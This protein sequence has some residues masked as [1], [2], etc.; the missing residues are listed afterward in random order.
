MSTNIICH[1]SSAG[2]SDG[3]SSGNSA[4]TPNQA[5]KPNEPS[6][7]GRAKTRRD[8]EQLILQA[9]ECI[10]AEHGFKGATTSQIA[11]KAKLPKAN[12]HYYFPTKE[13]LYRKVIDRIF[14]IWLEAASAFD[15][16]EEP[17]DAFTCYISKKMDIS[18]NHPM[19]SKVW[20]NEILHKAPVIHDY[21]QTTLRDWTDNRVKIIQGWI[22]D[23]KMA[24][25]NPKFLLYMIWATTQHYADFNYQINT[26]NN[27]A[28]LT[29]EQFE[30]AKAQAIK[31][32]LTGIGIPVGTDRSTD[33]TPCKSGEVP[34]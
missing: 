23:G 14:N 7:R 8:N 9:A 31:I 16:C 15:D 26:L 11:K 28:P 1:S 34:L 12:L 3:G 6:K 17:A 20:A 32:I 33:A 4:R 2:S 29:D 18:R 22:D 30:E 27:G 25:V 10:F 13:A 19:G 5:P 21:M 24:P